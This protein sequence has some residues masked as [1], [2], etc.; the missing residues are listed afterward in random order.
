MKML[1]RIFQAIRAPKLERPKSWKPTTA[2]EIENRLAT[3]T[4]TFSF[5]KKDGGLR[6]V[7]GTRN[8]N[9]IHWQKHPMGLKEPSPTVVT[10]FDT[11]IQ[12]WRSMRR[13]TKCFILA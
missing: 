4:I 13:D 5:I 2:D 12:D 11:Q 10:F 3:G 8:L 6:E 1:K 7:I 9:Q